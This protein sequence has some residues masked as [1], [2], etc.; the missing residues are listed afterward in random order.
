MIENF[1]SAGSEGCDDN[2]GDFLYVYDERDENAPLLAQLNGSPTDQ[3]L[4]QDTF[5]TTGRDMYVRFATDAGN[6][7]LTNTI[8]SPGFY[9]EWSVLDNGQECDTDFRMT[10][11]MGIVGHNNEQL[12]GKTPE[13]CMAEYVPNHS[14][15]PYDSMEGALLVERN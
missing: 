8:A 13:Q 4:M 12:S 14:A 3:V 15:I 9:A 5:T 6:Y 10:P 2:G 7:G 1:V 11:G